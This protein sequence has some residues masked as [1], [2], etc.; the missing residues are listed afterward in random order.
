MC[1]LRCSVCNPRGGDTESEEAGTEVW[2]G[3]GS[4]HCHTESTPAVTRSELPA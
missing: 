2:H 4:E 3:L 1:L